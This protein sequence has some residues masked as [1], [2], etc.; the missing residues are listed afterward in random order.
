MANKEEKED[1]SRYEFNSVKFAHELMVD[2]LGALIPGALFLFCII[3]CIV[4]PI[5]CYSTQ[6]NNF[7]F[8]MKDGDWFWIVAF[9]SFLILSYVLG[10]IFYRADIKMPDKADIRREQEKKLKAFVDGLP[11]NDK[12]KKVKR[13]KH[14]KAQS[15]EEFELSDEDIKILFSNEV[16]KPAAKRLRYAATLLEGEIK[17]LALALCDYEKIIQEHPD[18]KLK[19]SQEPYGKK[20]KENCDNALNIINAVKKDPQKY[21]K[22][23]Y[24][25]KI[26]S[27]QKKK[28]FSQDEVYC[29]DKLKKEL[30]EFRK[31]VLCI[32]FPEAIVNF[33]NNKNDVN[34]K[35]DDLESNFPNNKGNELYYDIAKDLFPEIDIIPFRSRNVLINTVKIIPMVECHTTK[36]K[37]D[38]LRRLRFR[39]RLYQINH[40]WLIEEIRLHKRKKSNIFPCELFNIFMVSYLI[41]L[42]QNESGCATERRCDFPYMSYYKYLLKR[43]LYNLLQYADWATSSARTK[44]H[45]NKY[46]IDLQVHVPNAYAVII[47]NESHIRMASSSWHVAKVIRNLSWV[48]LIFTLLVCVS[49]IKYNVRTKGD[50]LKKEQ[51]EK[52]DGLKFVV[53][54]QEG[55]SHTFSMGEQKGLVNVTTDSKDNISSAKSENQKNADKTIVSG[56]SEVSANSESTGNN[57]DWNYVERIDTVFPFIGYTKIANIFLAILFPLLTLLLSY[58]I[59]KKIPQFIHYQRLREI[60]FTLELYMRWEEAKEKRDEKDLHDLNIR[61]ASVNLPPISSIESAKN[62]YH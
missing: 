41:L 40:N 32:M 62:F 34:L 58:Y 19:G 25:D 42:M 31:Y 50:G 10:L 16:I 28:H 45:I 37:S 8:L 57:D 56:T 51:N 23:Y 49:G 48:V 11:V 54:Y 22:A 38:R 36:A 43:R 20:F 2:V 15:D 1:D 26:T 52:Q 14:G 6:K 47:K 61:R 55:E 46:K 18:D 44:N 17:P 53:N 12:K 60:Y 4:F 39:I 7:G 9:L 30:D 21:V 29:L 3:L 35:N 13:I 27:D 59:L 33:D 24:A 5:I